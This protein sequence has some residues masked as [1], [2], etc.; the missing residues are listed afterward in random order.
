MDFFTPFV[1]FA[2]VGVQSSAFEKIYCLSVGISRHK[3]FDLSNFTWGKSIIALSFFFKK[4]AICTVSCITESSGLPAW[5]ISLPLTVFVI[6]QVSTEALQS[7]YF[8]S[9]I[10]DISIGSILS[11]P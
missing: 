10:T 3:Y 9:R 5:P 6:P 1:S 8:I 2:K 4:E 11:N 7:V